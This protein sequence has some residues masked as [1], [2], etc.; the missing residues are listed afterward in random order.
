MDATFLNN[1]ITALRSGKYK[2]GFGQYYDRHNDCACTMGVGL[3][4]NNI[5]LLPDGSN[6]VS[7]NDLIM[8]LNCDGHE[9]SLWYS[10]YEL[11]DRLKTP[12]DQMALWLE[13]NVQPINPQTAI[14]D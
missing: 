14:K 4:A 8:D 3:L 7:S 2:Q 5:E 11:N 9:R 10:I 1:W 6:C 13:R 12:F